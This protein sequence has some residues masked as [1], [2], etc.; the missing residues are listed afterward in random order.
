MRGAA[1]I[2]TEIAD[3]ADLDAL[4]AAA[5]AAWDAFGGLDVALVAHGS[6]P[7]QERAETAPRGRAA[8]L[9]R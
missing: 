1:E 8:R 3:L 6:L 9:W 2:V 7:D 5:A 4:D